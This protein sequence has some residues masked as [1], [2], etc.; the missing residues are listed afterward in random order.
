MI[1]LKNISKSF[2]D[3]KV[4]DN[5]NIEIKEGEFYL[6]KGE[7]GK[8]K[9]T[10][11]NIIGMLEEFDEGELI[12]MDT[13]N[14]KIDKSSGRTLL[15]ENISYLFQNYGLV[16]NETIKENLNMALKFKS[17]SKKEKEEAMKKVLK[18]VKL[19]KE[20]DTKIYTLS[21]GEQQRVALAKVILKDS[22]IILCDEPTGSLDEKNRDEIL[23]ILLELKN[24]NKTIV[25]VS[26]DPIMENYVD[27]V[28]NL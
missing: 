13:L 25:M 22:K 17:S 2:S 7:S 9:T 18:R 15:K 11:L 21:G 20:L 23:K 10:I 4:L 16:D 19:D 1:Q 27:T 8:G 12:I 26:H 3:K 28:Y 14:P 6:I 5:I 24:E